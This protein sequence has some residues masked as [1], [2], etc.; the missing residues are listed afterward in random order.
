MRSKFIAYRE[1]PPK[2]C[3]IFFVGVVSIE[4]K[5][6][7]CEKCYFSPSLRLFVHYLRK[8]SS[9]LVSKVPKKLS[10]LSEG[11]HFVWSPHVLCVCVLHTGWNRGSCF[12]RSLRL[13][14]CSSWFDSKDLKTK[15]RR[16]AKIE[17]CFV[18]CVVPQSFTAGAWST[19]LSTHRPLYFYL[20]LNL[21][22]LERECVCARVVQTS[23]CVCTDT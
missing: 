1:V 17:I 22:L 4:S 12:E 8:G 2:S 15:E 6:S 14:P 16:L 9:F 11:G 18:S 3:K 7:L 5:V 20:P 23:K 21:W 10:S 13:I 19:D